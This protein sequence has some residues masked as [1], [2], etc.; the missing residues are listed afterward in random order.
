MSHARGYIPDAAHKRCLLKLSHEVL[1]ASPTFP[2]ACSN[3]ALEGAILD[4][5]K[6]GSCTGHGTSQALQ[7]SAA[8]VGAPLPFRPSPR[9]I[10]DNA[11]LAEGTTLTDDGAQPS[12]VVAT[13]AAQGIRA[14]VEPSPEGFASD[15][16]ASNVNAVPTLAEVAAEKQHLE[17]GA[18][19]VDMTVPTWKAQLCAGVSQFGAAGIGI[20]V[21]TGFEGYTPASGPVASI[22]LSDPNG[23]GHWLA[24][25]S[26]RTGTDGKVVFRGPNS[27]GPDWGDAGHYEITE[28]ALSSACSDCYV[29]RTV[30]AVA[31]SMTLLDRIRAAACAII[32]RVAA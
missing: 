30:A 17:P 21:D 18:F 1:G 15:V 28:D 14:L 31:P 4:Q 10:Y 24:V 27:W 25:T 23:G 9:G 3:E 32:A 16:D 7:V 12:D 29:F 13:L 2:P 20:F 11:R 6:T 22:D 26:Y 19:R 8:K 5:N